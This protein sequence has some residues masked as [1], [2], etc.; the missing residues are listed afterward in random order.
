MSIT[1]LTEKCIAVKLP[2]IIMPVFHLEEQP[3]GQQGLRHSYGTEW[4]YL[5]KGSWAIL[6]MSDKLT[7]EEWKKVVI[8]WDSGKYNDYERHLARVDTAT[9]SGLSLL[10]SK[11]IEVP[12]LILINNG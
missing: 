11:G 5:P 6:G 4:V 1:H 3:D 10:K 8:R 2:D 12:H 9:E 7:E